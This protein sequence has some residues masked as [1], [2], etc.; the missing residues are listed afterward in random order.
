MKKIWFFALLLAFA[1]LAVG[2]GY[3]AWSEHI[4]I[5]GT[6]NTGEVDWYIYNSAMQTDIGLDWTCDPGFD[7]EPVQ[8][9]KNVG[10]TTLTPVDTDGDGDKDTLRVTVSRGYPGYYNYVSFVAKNNGTIPIAVQTPVVDNP[11]PV[12]IAAGYQDN[13]GTLVLP[14]QTIGFGF[15]FLILDGANES[16]TYS[17]TIQFPG[18]QWNKYT[19]E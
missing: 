3:A 10:S 6:V 8:L 7:T 18:I 17:F 11:N 16:S 19:G 5:A 9:D 1:L 14:G 13:S 12:A 15:Q 4:T 2:A